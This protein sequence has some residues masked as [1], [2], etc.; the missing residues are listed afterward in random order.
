MMTLAAKRVLGLAMLAASTMAVSGTARADAIQP[1]VARPDIAP[2][3]ADRT[4]FGDCDTI[5]I[6]AN[7]DESLFGSNSADGV[8]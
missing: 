8:R 3:R 4:A 7:S 1:A 5:S 6:R 2:L